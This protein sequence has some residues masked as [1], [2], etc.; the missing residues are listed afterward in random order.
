[1]TKKGER[2]RRR[3]DFSG[4]RDHRGRGTPMRTALWTAFLE[5][6]REAG[7]L[8]DRVAAKRRRT[9]AIVG[10]PPK[11]EGSGVGSRA[12]GSPNP[13]RRSGRRFRRLAGNL[14]NR[15][16][17]RCIQFMAGTLAGTLSLSHKRRYLCGFT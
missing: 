5:M 9:F 7:K 6:C 2:W 12:C 16:P 13:A 15:G 8:L 14:R 10:W 11:A 4:R 1:M 3:G 17:D